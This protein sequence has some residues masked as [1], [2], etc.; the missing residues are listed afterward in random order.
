METKKSNLEVLQNIA[1]ILNQ[2]L[3]LEPEIRTTSTN[4]NYLINSIVEVLPMM[5]LEP[6]KKQ[7]GN[8]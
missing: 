1:A 6:K 3:G 2:H 5:R 4:P 8:K 7:D